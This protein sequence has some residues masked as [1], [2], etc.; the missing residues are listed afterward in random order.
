MAISPIGDNRDD[1][2]LS[3][4]GGIVEV[5]FGDRPEPTRDTDDP[6]EN[7]AEQI[8]PTDL[9]VMAVELLEHIDADIASR[10]EWERRMARGIAVMGL[11]DDPEFTPPFIGASEVTHPLLAEAIVQFQSR[12]VTEIFPPGGPV[13]CIVVGESD[14]ESEAQRERVEAHMNY[15]LTIED[16]GYFP[17]VDK[18]LFRLPIEGSVFRKCFYD[19]L[20]GMTKSRA[21]KAGDLIVPYSASSLED[22]PR[23][24]HRMHVQPNDVK[25]LQAVGY[26]RATSITDMPP[27]EKEIGDLDEAI[28]TA[29]SRT[30][31]EHPDDTE[32]LIYECCCDYDLPGDLADPE[33]IARPYIVTI[34]ADNQDILAIRRNWRDEDDLKRKRLYYT[35]YQYLPGLGFYGYGLF[36]MIGGL[37]EAATGAVRALLDSAAFATLQGGFKSSDAAVKGGDM[38]LSPG[39]WKDIDLTAEELDKAFKTIPWKEPSPAMFQLLG[40]LTE[41]GQRFASTT[42]S[43]VGD[44]SNNGPVGTTVALIEQGSKVYSAIHKR[45]HFAAGCEFSCLAELNGEY[46]PDEGYPYTVEGEERTIARA[47]YDDRVDVVPVSDPNIFSATQRI[48]IAQTGMQLAVQ[49]PQLYDMYEVHKRMHVALR[50]PA[51]DEILI[52]PDQSE[53]LDPMTENAA[54]LTGRAV[55]VFP[56]QDHQAHIAVHMAFLQHPE[57]GGNKTAQKMIMG[58]MMAHIAQHAA[59]QYLIGM[60]MQGVPVQ[61]PD[62]GAKR[63]SD[64]VKAPLDPMTE[65]MVA[66]Q[67]AAQAQLLSK[68]RGVPDMQQDEASAER[69]KAQIEQAKLQL[70]MEEMK[71]DHMIEREKLM[72]SVA[73]D[74]AKLESQEQIAEQKAEIERL[75]AELADMKANADRMLKKYEIDVKAE[76]ER[77]KMDR[78]DGRAVYEKGGGSIEADLIPSD[79]DDPESRVGSIRV[80]RTVPKSAGGAFEAKPVYENPDDP[81]SKIKTITVTRSNGK[82]EDDSST[83]TTS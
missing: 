26:Y 66:Q 11:R 61:L 80:R 2:T 76:I 62:L 15:Q 39:E 36:H 57:F 43:M 7:L 70:Q 72:A 77:E 38:E 21:V 60:Q 3:R 22:T 50:T 75:K 35:H 29:E 14:E 55:K 49:A 52:D 58:A 48:A 79:P 83:E 64:L 32:H 42:E 4:I 20:T 78:E 67:Q 47:D 73:G 54:I 53:H 81:I 8:S 24:T 71:L 69:M 56:E 40:M 44:A 6:G 12:A 74:K 31:S 82:A 27:A 19:Q 65:N 59:Y 28:D 68:V 16:R 18:M 9:G 37:A 46:L 13:K 23:I 34:D 63:G 30:L 33:G 51:M 1:A 25:K 17:D 5:D 41:S 10:E 45:I